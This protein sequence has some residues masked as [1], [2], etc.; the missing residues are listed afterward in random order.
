MPGTDASS[1][2]R[3]SNAYA[4]AS[5]RIASGEQFASIVAADGSTRLV[6]LLTFLNGTVL[7][8]I[9]PRTPELLGEISA[10]FSGRWTRRCNRLR[11]PQRIAN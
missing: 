5:H 10:D 3:A 8:E 6:W 4:F 11:T 7:A 2:T 1:A 9:R